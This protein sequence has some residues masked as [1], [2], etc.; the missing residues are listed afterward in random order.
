MKTAYDT[1][2]KRFLAYVH[3]LFKIAYENNL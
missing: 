3:K 1:F 2:H